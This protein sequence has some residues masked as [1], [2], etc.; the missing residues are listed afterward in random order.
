MSFAALPP[1]PISGL[2][3]SEY[4]LLAAIHE[5]IAAL[6]GQS[7]ATYKAVVSGQIGVSVPEAQ[8]QDVDFSGDA[9]SVISNM[10]A[11]LQYLIND[12]QGLRDAL[13]ALIT[14]LRS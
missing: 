8:V 11:T 1:V 10:G 13:N 2:T 7:D 12:V 4:Q 14:Q 6:T 5:N 3:D 9:N